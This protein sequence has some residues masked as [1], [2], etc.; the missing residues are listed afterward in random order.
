M[1]AR[2]ASPPCG[3][4]R[5]RDPSTVLRHD[6]AFTRS[7]RSICTDRGARQHSSVSPSAGGGRPRRESQS[8]P[9]DIVPPRA[10]PC[11]QDVQCPSRSSRASVPNRSGADPRCGDAFNLG[12][13]YATTQPALIVAGRRGEAEVIE[14]DSARIRLDRSRERSC[15]PAHRLSNN[16]APAPPRPCAADGLV[17]LESGA[18]CAAIRPAPAAALTWST[19][20]RLITPAF[21]QCHAPSPTAVLS[22]PS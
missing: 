1:N 2:V 16:S 21:G 22:L 11:G 17:R 20:R 5:W 4:H 10:D 8:W 12:R 19:S 13:V 3:A 18:S 15:R 9:A 6:L 14:P 7:M